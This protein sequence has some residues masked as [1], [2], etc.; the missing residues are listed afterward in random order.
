MISFDRSCS[1]EIRKCDE[2]FANPAVY[3]IKW[4]AHLEEVREQLRRP[5]VLLLSKDSLP[6]I[7][8]LAIFEDHLICAFS[9]SILDAVTKP[10][11]SRPFIMK[12]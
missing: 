6:V 4:C 7:V 12:R 2:P 5:P 3:C 8:V 9:R 1:F 11:S 10:T